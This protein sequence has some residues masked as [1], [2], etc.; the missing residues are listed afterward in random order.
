MV[1]RALPEGGKQS[2]KT[3]RC[4]KT[5]RYAAYVPTQYR[6]VYL[7]HWSIR[8]QK[9]MDKKY[10]R[11]S[12]PNTEGDWRKMQQKIAKIMKVP[13]KGL[14]LPLQC[15]ADESLRGHPKEWRP[16]EIS[17]PDKEA[18]ISNMIVD[19]DD[20]PASQ[21]YTE[22]G[23]CVPHPSETVV[24]VR[25]HGRAHSALKVLNLLK[26]ALGLNHRCSCY[27]QVVPEQLDEYEKV[28]K[29]HECETYLRPGAAGAGGQVALARA[30]CKEGAHLIIVDDNVT[31][32]KVLSRNLEQGE[33]SVFL[34][35]AWSFMAQ[36]GCGGWTVNYCSNLWG[37]EFQNPNDPQVAGLNLLYGALFG[38]AV[39]HHQDRLLCTRTGSVMDDVE[40]TLRTYTLYPAGLIVFQAYTVT[41]KK[42]GGTWE[43]GAGGISAQFNTSRDHQI[44]MA[45]QLNILCADFPDLIAKGNNRS[46]VFEWHFLIKPVMLCKSAAM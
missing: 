9:Q 3:Q 20:V 32:I 35:R 6:C 42:K 8:F 31:A 29:E 5:A 21:E 11:L 2:T 44:F 4:S 28:F 38:Q 16:K 7:T 33:L 25:S 19:A 22:H 34:E 24:V 46:K 27:V 18:S 23:P 26:N 39:R 40:R 37:K 41:K 45:Q 14:S 15:G 43:Q 1:R 17:V 30:A 13:A 36:K 10:V 12:C